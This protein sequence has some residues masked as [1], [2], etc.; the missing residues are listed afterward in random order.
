MAASGKI[1]M[2]T[3]DGNKVQDAKKFLCRFMDELK[4]K[5]SKIF[6]GVEENPEAMEMVVMDPSQDMTVMEDQD[7][8]G[9][10]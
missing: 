8:S 3:M 4:E 1:D 9:N 2:E 10:T 7:S 5:T 6:T